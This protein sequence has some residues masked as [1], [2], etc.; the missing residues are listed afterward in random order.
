MFPWL[1][2]H[3]SG[4]FK[5]AVSGSDDISLVDDGAATHEVTSLEHDLV[6]QPVLGAD[7]LAPTILPAAG[8]ALAHSQVL[9]ALFR[10]RSEKFKDFLTGIK[11]G[12][13]VT[14][15]SGGNSVPLGAARALR[16]NRRERIAD[17]RNIFLMV[18]GSPC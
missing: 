6:G 10:I 15:S 14:T 4:S 5:E 16:L 3:L 1:C 11:F 13:R 12:E 18:P 8:T 17:R 2:W 7:L 9:M